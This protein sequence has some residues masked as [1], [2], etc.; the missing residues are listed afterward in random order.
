MKSIAQQI[1]EAK[2]EQ[3]VRFIL[4]FMNWTKPTGGERRRFL[5]LAYDRLRDI[6]ATSEHK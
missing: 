5:R 4:N 2:T 1:R 3:E 6:N